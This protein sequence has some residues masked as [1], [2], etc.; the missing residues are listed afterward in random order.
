M[1][2]DDLNTEMETDDE[3]TRGPKFPIQMYISEAGKYYL[4]AKYDLAMKLYNTALDREPDNEK[5]L[6]GRAMCNMRLTNFEEVKQDAER[7][8]NTHPDNCEAKVLIGEAEYFLGDFE[9]SFLTFYRGYAAKKNHYK[10]KCGH[11]MSKKAIDNSLN[12]DSPITFDEEDIQNLRALGEDEESDQPTKYEIKDQYTPYVDFFSSILEDDS[13]D[14][15]IRS[16]SMFLKNYL[17]G[18]QIFWKAQNPKTSKN[19]TKGSV[20]QDKRINRKGAEDVLPKT[21]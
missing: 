18:R 16:E 15:I 12:P 21:T 9:T 4:I 10:L 19:S 8:L 11:Q 20:G 3:V 7:I 14:D 13:I 6:I 5:C 2:T 17:E 1:E